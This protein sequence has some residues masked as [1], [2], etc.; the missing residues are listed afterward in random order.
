MEIEKIAQILIYYIHAPMGGV[1][2]LAGGVALIVKKGNRTHKKAGLIFYYAML[3][4]ALTAFIISI[5]PN[6]ESPFLFSVGMFSTY[7]LLGGYRSLKFRNKTHNVFIDKL[8]A[9]TMVITGLIMII[10][11]IIFHERVDVVLL[12][13]GL[14]GISFGIRDIRLFQNK[15][16]LREKWL[17]LHV[18][19]MTGGY[20]AS[21]TAFFVVNQFLP[22]LFNW[23][24]PG[25]IGSVYI[26]YWIKKLNRKN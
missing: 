9:V 8:I 4:S 25:V 3:I 26:S 21:I 15:H 10:Y 18:G 1:A 5:M 24:L 17:T 23:L 12:I 11:P 22:Y 7:F 6:H 19:K 20:I 14:V 2:L 13:F 16:K